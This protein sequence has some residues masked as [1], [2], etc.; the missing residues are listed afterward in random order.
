MKDSRWG[1]RKC[2]TVVE[3]R[4]VVVRSDLKHRPE[5]K[6]NIKLT[7]LTHVRVGLPLKIAE[8]GVPLKVER[9]PVFT[10]ITVTQL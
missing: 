1:R 5:P 6:M 10:E 2:L 8:L 4:R 7:L 9:D 3:K